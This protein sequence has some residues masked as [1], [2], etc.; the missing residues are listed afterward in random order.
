MVS[1]ILSYVNLRLFIDGLHLFVAETV[2]HAA[3]FSNKKAGLLEKFNSLFLFKFGFDCKILYIWCYKNKL[4]NMSVINE[5]LDGNYQLIKTLLT[6]DV[7]ILIEHVKLMEEN[8]KLDFITNIVDEEI[9]DV[10]PV[11]SLKKFLLS[12]K[13]ELVKI[14]DRS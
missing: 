6:D 9:F 14:S 11:G 8:D 3:F 2:S 13:D 7:E 5:I 12:F 1:R 4:Q 10:Y